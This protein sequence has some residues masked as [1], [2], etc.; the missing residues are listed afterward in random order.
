ML[1]GEYRIRYITRRNRMAGLT[2]RAIVVHVAHGVIALVVLLLIVEWSLRR[3][4][5]GPLEVMRHQLE[6]IHR[7]GK[8]SGLPPVDR[9]LADL[10]SAVQGIGPAV[11]SQIAEWVESDRRATVAVMFARITHVLIPPL[12]SALM[13]GVQPFRS[14]RTR[15]QSRDRNRTPA[16]ARP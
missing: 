15:R 7:G 10:S 12:R 14:Q 13:R 8:V 16:A 3:R 11:E 5:F 1:D 9:E 6:H 4:I 2:R